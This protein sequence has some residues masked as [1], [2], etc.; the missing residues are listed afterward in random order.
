MA[1]A[2]KPSSTMPKRERL[3]I[4]GLIVF[5]LILA[6]FFGVR[7]VVSFI[8]IQQTG[9]QPG[10]TD[11]E[12]IRG[13]MTI[14][15]IAKAYGAPEEY[16]FEHIGVQAEGNRHKSLGQLNLEYAFGQPT[17]ILDAV[18]EAIRQYHGEQPPP[19]TASP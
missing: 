14:P 19:A 1:H 15:Y 10:V 3:L 17:A 13:W 11:V 7:A 8:R 6:G 9:L 16:L 5:G 12:A 4:G 2:T 18:K